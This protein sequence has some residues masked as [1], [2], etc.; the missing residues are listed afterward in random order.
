MPGRGHDFGDGLG[1]GDQPRGQA[2]V[3]PGDI[4]NQ[5]THPRISRRFRNIGV[6]N[7]RYHR[8]QG[9]IGFTKHRSG[10]RQFPTEFHH[11]WIRHTSILPAPEIIPSLDRMKKILKRKHNQ[12]PP[13]L[14]QNMINRSAIV[15]GRPQQ[16]GDTELT[17]LQP[18][19]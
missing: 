12:L 15:P 6:L 19:R 13:T 8:Y 7:F 3:E 5:Q 10:L 16:A 9:G 4:S 17:P 2:R 1:M 14:N 18:H 11:A